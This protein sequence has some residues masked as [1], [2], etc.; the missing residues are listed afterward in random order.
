MIGIYMIKNTE[1]GKVYIGSSKN[2]C[3]RWNN[4][5]SELFQRIHKNYKLQD[6]FDKYGIEKFT[7]SVLE[8]VKSYKNL[9]RIEQNHLDLIDV[10]SNYNILSYTKI[11]NKKRIKTNVKL[12]KFK[13]KS[14]ERKKLKQNIKIFENK[15]LNDFGD[16]RTSLSKG[17]YNKSKSL[18]QLKNHISNFHKNYR[19]NESFYWTTFISFQK[20]LSAA[21]TRSRFMALTDDPYEKRNNL[22]YTVNIFINPLI[23]DDVEMSDDQYALNSILSWILNV[24]DVTE[25]IHIYIP[26]RRMRDLLREWVDNKKKTGGKNEK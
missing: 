16:K 4:H 19:K 18:T 8:V 6:D 26:S 5:M 1:N 12:L 15:R 10:E 20:Q 9:L 11:D 23:K 7:F 3:R 25:E 24:S 2:V 13:L 17:W 21:G 14:W 22:A